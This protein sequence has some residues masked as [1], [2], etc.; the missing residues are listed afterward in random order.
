MKN[1]SLKNNLIIKIVLALSVI[2]LA[3]FGLV[4]ALNTQPQKVVKADEGDVLVRDNIYSFTELDDGTYSIGA[5]DIDSF[6][7]MIS[8]L[9]NAWQYTFKHYYYFDSNGIEVASNSPNIA[10]TLEVTAIAANGFQESDIEVAIIEEGIT[11]IGS[12][13]FD[14]CPDLNTVSIPSTMALVDSYA[15]EN[16]GLLG[17]VTFGDGEGELT[18]EEYAFSACIN[19]TSITLPDCLLNIGQYC[20]ESTGLTC[21]TVPE[22][23]ENIGQYA[24][25]E[26]SSL[27]SITLPFV[28]LSDSEDNT[29]SYRY[30]YKI[31]GDSTSSIPASLVD[32]TITG[33]NNVEQ[34][35]WD[36]AFDGCST[37]E[38]SITIGDGVTRIGKWAFN[39]C[40][41]D[42]F[43]IGNDVKFIDEHAFDNCDEISTFELGTG[44]LHIADEVLS[45]SNGSTIEGLTDIWTTSNGGT[46]LKCGSNNYYYLYSVDNKASITSFTVHSDCKVIGNAAFEQAWALETLSFPSTLKSF[47]DY[48]ITNTG[49]TSITIPA[50]CEYIGYGA[51]SE[52]ESFETVTFAP[53]SVLKTIEGM[54]FNDC[55]ELT[56]IA[57]PASVTYIGNAAFSS[58]RSLQEITLPFTGLNVSQTRVS[59]DGDQKFFIIF[60]SSVSDIP[61]SLTTVNILGTASTKISGGAFRDCTHLVSVNIGNHVT[62]IGANTFNGCSSLE[63]LTIPF[64]GKS[65]SDYNSQYNYGKFFYIFGPSNSVSVANVPASL[66]KVTVNGGQISNNAFNGSSNIEEIVLNEGVTMIGNYSFKN[67]TNL[68]R[69]T[70]ANS[71]I[72]LG[73]SPFGGCSCIDRVNFTRNGSGYYFHDGA[74]TLANQD[75]LNGYETAWYK[76]SPLVLEV[77]WAGNGTNVTYIGKNTFSGCVNLKSLSFPNAVEYVG[78][79]VVPGDFQAT[80]VDSVNNLKYLGNSENPYMICWFTTDPDMTTYEIN[81]NCKVIAGNAFSSCENLTSITIP[82]SVKSIG[83]FA[84][85][86]CNELSQVNLNQGLERIGEGAFSDTALVSVTI[87]SSV[88]QL[89]MIGYGPFEAIDEDDTA[90]QSMIINPHALTEAYIMPYYDNWSSMIWYYGDTAV[91]FTDGTDVDFSD[92]DAYYIDSSSFGGIDYYIELRRETYTPLVVTL[93]DSDLTTTLA[94]YHG[95]TTPNIIPTKAGFKFIG[96]RYGEG[97]TSAIPTYGSELVDANSDGNLTLY[98]VWGYDDLSTGVELPSKTSVVMVSVGLSVVAI[99]SVAGIVFCIKRIG[100]YKKKR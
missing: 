76:I 7:D 45:G 79:N 92:G 13:A 42:E 84:F 69:I 85:S 18:L 36:N 78:L 3:V 87:P 55:M 10:E 67:C 6:D 71:D 24:F 73:S 44:I 77:I 39:D 34:E 21:I 37:I 70:I 99:L 8:H 11:T 4:F 32:V 27:A 43:Y 38:N 86:F 54:A 41:T 48:C 89:D 51:F 47:D 22:N 49:L 29:S 96:W 46:Y 25:N 98:A 5:C 15:F 28:G 81:P 14:G 19:L 31:F 91:D 74:L 56:E 50:T 9:T 61:E 65:V 59:S 1:I 58:C 53:N 26:C 23:V 64:V 33:G 30:F 97:N 94:E 35:I 60:G 17:T 63:E 83:E 95:I 72:L 40:Y 100:Y 66:T 16:C 20:F 62:L 80:V 75:I 88:T 93:K 82:A 90:T 52:N 2:A 12:Y 68:T 57:V